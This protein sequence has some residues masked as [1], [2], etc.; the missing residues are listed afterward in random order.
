MTRADASLVE[1]EI[2]RVAGRVPAE[3]LTPLRTVLA[4]RPW[5]LWATLYVDASGAGGS[6]SW[7]A[8]GRVSDEVARLLGGSSYLTASGPTPEVER[9]DSGAAEL[10]G[11]AHAVEAALRAWPW[12]G[13]VGLRCDNQEAVRVVAG[14]GRRRPRPELAAALAVLRTAPVALRAEWVPGHGRSPTARKAAWNDQV[15]RLARTVPRRTT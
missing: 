15:D 4:A 6:W 13:G 7:G 1:R 10:W 9:D 5:G 3:L 8:R 14:T 2:A 11:A 12:L